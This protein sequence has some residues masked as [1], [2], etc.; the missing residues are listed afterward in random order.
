M[1]NDLKWSKHVEQIAHKANRELGLLKHTVGGKNKDIF[2]NLYKT[3]VRPI[4]E[5]A[6]PVWSPQLQTWTK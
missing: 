5:Y 6:Y 3:L 4:L 2:S 1:A